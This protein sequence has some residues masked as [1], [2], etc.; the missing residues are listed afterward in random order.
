MTKCLI[1][2]YINGICIDLLLENGEYI[3]RQHII[4]GNCTCR[5]YSTEEKARAYYNYLCRKA[6]RI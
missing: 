3:V 4:T 5:N 2:R 6:R 1:S